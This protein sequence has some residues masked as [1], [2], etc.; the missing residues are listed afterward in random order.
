MNKIRIYLDTS[1]ISHLL[2]DDTPDRMQDTLNLWELLKFGQF[3]TVISSLTLAELESCPE[4]KR[5]VLLNHLAEIDYEK[6]QETSECIALSEEY[7]QDGVLRLKS[8]DD[9]DGL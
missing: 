7:L 1:V 8:R 2:A 5:T 6:I 9:D 4:P 3:K